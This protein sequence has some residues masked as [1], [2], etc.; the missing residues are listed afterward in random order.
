M[1]KHFL[2]FAAISRIYYHR[3]VFYLTQEIFPSF[4]EFVWIHFATLPTA[5]QAKLGDIFEAIWFFTGGDTTGQ[6][7]SFTPASGGGLLAKLNQGRGYWFITKTEAFDRSAPLPGFL[8]GPV[9]PVTMQLDGVLFDPSGA[10][11]SLPATVQLAEAGWHLI[12][13]IGEQSRPVERGV[14]GVLF[15]TRQF[16]SLIEF[17]KFIDFDPATD[18]VEIVGGVFNPLFAGDI[19]NPGDTMEIGRGFYIFMN[20]AGTHTP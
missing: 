4:L 8:E 3:T 16:N 19:A 10:T 9:I 17:Q 11:P 2:F 14:R 7:Q 1:L 5:E 15:P 13:L 6:W 18:G 12:A 20:Q